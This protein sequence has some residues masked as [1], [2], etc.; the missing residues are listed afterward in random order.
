[1]NIAILGGSFDPVH[2]EHINIV[3]AA[4]EK[5]NTD[6]IIVMPAFVPPHK[7][8]KN[9]A[10][11]QDRF[12]MAKLAFSKIKNCE[13]SSYEINAGG[14]SYT[15]LT[16]AYF[17]KKYPDAH[18]YLLVGSDMLKD[19]YSWK[20]P[21]LILEE[22]DLVVCNREGDPVNFK[23]E[24]LKFFAKFRKVFKVLDYVGRNISSTKVR[25]LC[26]F[27]EDLK[28]YLTEDVID[29][30]EANQLY[31]VP[32]VKDALRYL[33]PVRAKHSMRVALMAAEVGMKY[34][35]PESTLILASA[36]HDTAKNLDLSAP[37]L[38]GFSLTENVPP[39]VLHQF[40][41]AYLAEHTFGITDEDILNAVRYHTSGRPN[42]SMLEKILFLADMLEQGR[43]F[44]H[45]KKLREW[46]YKDIN[47]CMYRC[48]R[49][50]IKYLKKSRATIYPLTLR[51]FEYYK[52]N[53]SH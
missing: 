31:R 19:F 4:A 10:S 25:V 48:L 36:L 46:Y 11:A 14:T 53:R 24:Q 33:K 37:E 34:K 51:A 49:H 38:F 45:V 28:P 2:A 12:A 16:V 30:I 35:I 44:P 47:E 41:G 7:Q 29:Y 6:K 17:R 32:H 5:L 15:Y 39:S 9:M 8:G 18:F 43:T 42:M 27:G 20:N 1:M 3:R 22:A 21:E 13:V 52:E 40:T 26:A 50:Q 23:T